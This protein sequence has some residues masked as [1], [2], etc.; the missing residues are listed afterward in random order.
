MAKSDGQ[1]PLNGEQLAELTR[2]DVRTVNYHLKLLVE[3]G[4]IESLGKP[5][6][7]SRT[8]DA[9]PDLV[10]VSSLTN[11][12]HKFVEAVREPSRWKQF[13]AWAGEKVAEAGLSTVL[14]LAIRFAPGS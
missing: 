11:E 1:L 10:L 13:L 8:S 3:A 4:W 2:A 9:V 12:G 5:H 7:T 14:Q 6:Y